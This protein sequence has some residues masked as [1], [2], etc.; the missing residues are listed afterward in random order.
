MKFAGGFI[1]YFYPAI[2]KIPD[3]LYHENFTVF[4]INLDGF[5]VSLSNICTIRYDP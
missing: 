4:F 3:D 1:D 2:Y 5:P